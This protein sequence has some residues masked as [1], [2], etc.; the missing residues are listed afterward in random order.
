MK[1]EEV[2]DDLKYFQ[3]TV[4]RD[5]MYAVD[6]DGNYKQVI[7]GGW[8]VKDDA[9]ETAWEEINEECEKVRAQVLKGLL[10]PLAYHMEK[11]IMKVSL[12]ATY[13]GISKSTI[14]KH[15]KP[16]HFKDID[17]D[18]LKKYADALRIT[19]EELQKV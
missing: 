11:N 18:T 9:L 12:L 2:P 3:N 10:S 13:S 16:K 8:E 4:I 15:L 1:V 6:E 5:V 19:V 14:K 17:F 7:S